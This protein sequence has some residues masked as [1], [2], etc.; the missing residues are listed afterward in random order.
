MNSNYYFED[1]E[2][3]IPIGSFEHLPKSERSQMRR[4]HIRAVEKARYELELNEKYGDP[5]EI[6]MGLSSFVLEG[7][8]DQQQCEL[9]QFDRVV[10]AVAEHFKMTAEEVAGRYSA[11]CIAIYVLSN[12]QRVARDEIANEFHYK[13]SKVIRRIEHATSQLSKGDKKYI[14]AYRAVLKSLG[15]TDLEPVLN[16]SNSQDGGRAT[17]YV[18]GRLDSAS[19]SDG[20][21][22]TLL[23]ER[24]GKARL[25]PGSITNKEKFLRICQWQPGSVKHLAIVGRELT[26]GI[27]RVRLVGHVELPVVK[28][29]CR[30]VVATRHVNLNDVDTIAVDGA[31]QLNKVRTDD[32]RKVLF[33]CM[34][35][36]AE[37]RGKGCVVFLESSVLEYA[38]HK[39]PE[40]YPALQEFSKGGNCVLCER[41]SGCDEQFLHYVSKHPRCIGISNDRFKD[42]DLSDETRHRIHSST[43]VSVPGETP[44]FQWH[45]LGEDGAD[46]TIA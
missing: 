35:R 38:Y 23:G 8:V 18:Q 1:D 5:F 4:E 31:N 13:T 12:N 30:S 46:L 21:T 15:E 2:T 19:L 11:S 26:T 22:F 34:V 20:L 17:E 42:H 6:G 27:L 41:S 25:R 7:D 16:L 10:S 29:A 28:K 33:Q 9:S 39:W 43:Y 45:W 24:Q 37:A 14:S 44:I 3:E 40:T 32:E 36:Y